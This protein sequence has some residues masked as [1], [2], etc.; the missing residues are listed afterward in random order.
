MEFDIELDRAGERLGT[1]AFL[2]TAEDTANSAYQ[3]MIGRYRNAASRAGQAASFIRPE[4]MAIP[5]AKMKKFLA[6]KELAPHRITLERMLRYKPHTLSH[7]RRKTAG[8]AGRNVG[9]RQPGVSPTGRRR[10]EIRH[11]EKRKR[12]AG[13]AEQR[14]VQL[15]LHSPKRAVRK[16]AFHQYYAQYK[17]H[18]NSL[19]ATLAG[20]IQRDVYY[21]KARGYSSALGASLFH[22]NVPASVYDNLIAAVHKHLPALYRYF[23][24]RRRKMKLPDIHHYDT[25]V[26]ILSE[27]ETQAHL[28]SGGESGRQVARTAGQRILRR[29]GSAA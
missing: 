24:L 1:Y 12:R 9:N 22:D 13:R 2:K 8:D 25:Y 7:R 6:A 20:S 28:G 16:N 27:L 5:A 11:G 19:A 21:A 29:A 14:H 3:R 26:P 23:E 10:S 17:G 4:I 15:F 18:E